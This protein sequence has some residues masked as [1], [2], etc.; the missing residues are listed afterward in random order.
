MSVPDSKKMLSTLLHG[1]SGLKVFFIVA[2]FFSSLVSLS[3]VD[4]GSSTPGKVMEF[5][6]FLRPLEIP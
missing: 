6:I 4:A 2:C 5:E 1:I 3:R